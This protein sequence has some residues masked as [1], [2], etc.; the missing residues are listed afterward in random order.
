MEAGVD[1]SFRDG[2]SFERVLDHYIFD[3]ELRL[4]VMDAIERIEVSVRTQWAFHVSHAQ[5]SHAHLNRGLFTKQR[6]YTGSLG[7]LTNEVGRSRETFIK[8][9]TEAYDES[10]PPIWAAVEVMSLGQLSRWYEN[11]KAPDLRQ[12]IA[13]TYGTDEKVLVSFL[14]H[15][16]LVRNVCAHHGRLWNRH[17]TITPKL[18]RKKPA[19]LTPCFNSAAPRQLYNTLVMFCYLMN[20]VSPGHHWKRRLLELL[21]EHNEVSRLPMGFPNSWQEFSF[22]RQDTSVAG[23]EETET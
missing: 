4:L 5:G 14:H 6:S 18:P 22:W 13:D 17:F 10:L 8:H 2:T 3:R 16:T 7:V 9:L 12:C 21:N 15:L 20:I 1:H 19:E 23:S 11:L